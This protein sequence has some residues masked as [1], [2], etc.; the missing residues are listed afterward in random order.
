MTITTP[1]TMRMSSTPIRTDRRG[2]LGLI[3]CASLTAVLPWRPAHALDADGAH[4]LIDRS[5]AE[6]EHAILISV[7]LVVLVEVVFLRDARAALVPAVAVPV[8]LM[9]RSLRPRC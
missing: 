1:M 4:A 5:L 9:R 2:L 6:V 3:G 7:V 8:S